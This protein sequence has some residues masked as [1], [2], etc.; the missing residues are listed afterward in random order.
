M[1]ISNVIDFRYSPDKSQTCIGLVDDPHKTLV[2]DDG[3][4]A[5]GYEVEHDLYYYPLLKTG[6][7]SRIVQNRGFRYRFKPEIM[8]RDILIRQEQDFGDPSAAIVTTTEYYKSSTLTFDCFAWQPND[9]L[10]VDVILWKLTGLESFKRTRASVALYV[11]GDEGGDFTVHSSD[12]ESCDDDNEFLASGKTLEGAYFICQKGDMPQELINLKS[13]KTAKAWSEKYWKNVKPFVN[14]ISIPDNG[15]MDMLKACGRNILQAREVHANIPTFQ[16]GPTCY[17]GLWVADG[18]FMLD[19]A[20]IMGYSKDAYDGIYA[21]MKRVYP[22]GRISEILF[23]E[24]ETAISMYTIIRQCEIMND[25]EKLK[26]LWPTVLRGFEFLKKRVL[27]SDDLSDSYPAKGLYPPSYGDGGTNGLEPEYTTP[28]WIMSSLKSCIKAAKKYSFAGAEDMQYIFDKM[29]KRYLEMAARD[30]KYTK[31]GLPYV[32]TSMLTDEEVAQ[33]IVEY[34]KY[35]VDGEVCNWGGYTPLTGTWT[36]AQ[37]IAPGELF[38][39]NDPIVTEFVELLDGFDNEEGIP[40]DSGWMSDGAVWGYAAMFYAQ[41]M[42]YANRPEKA[43]EYLY[44]FANHAS[45]ARVWREEQALRDSNHPGVWG[46]MPHNWGSAEFIR[47]I[48]NMLVLEKEDGLNLLEGFCQLWLP[49]EDC[50]L[51]IENSPTKFGAVTLK[52]KKTTDKTFGLEVQLALHDKPS[53]IRVKVPNG[54]SVSQE[55]VQG[56]CVFDGETQSIK[57]ELKIME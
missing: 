36:L 11:L 45:P 26:E 2:W 39:P 55:A 7:H 18:L 14:E 42:L 12:I 4:I 56:Y 25:L 3:S 44:A 49:S 52:M 32:P 29:M 6:I 43:I 46:D 21:L 30:R 38:K 5:F 1:S 23:H 28:L 48:R 27:S 47:L 24:K 40:R 31:D 13:A 8:H 22:D 57:I 53:A 10:R 37:V 51:I 15:L 9:E 54:F 17:R 50:D 35:N 34:E 33:H 20:H 16:V 41:V 19:A